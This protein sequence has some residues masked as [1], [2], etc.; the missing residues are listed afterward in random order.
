MWCVHQKSIKARDCRSYS[1]ANYKRDFGGETNIC[2]TCIESIN[3]VNKKTQKISNNFNVYDKPSADKENSTKASTLEMNSFD[4]QMNLNVSITCKCF[5]WNNHPWVQQFANKS[6]VE[7]IYIFTFLHF[8]CCCCARLL[9]ISILKTNKTIENSLNACD[10]VTFQEAKKKKDTECE[11]S[12]ERF[13]SSFV[14]ITNRNCLDCEFYA[15]SILR[16]HRLFLL[17]IRSRTQK[18]IE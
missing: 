18:Q 14:F 4:E 16:N 15:T 3:I 1:P 2:G 17:W 6:T 9:I 5:K 13:M 7:V 11:F 10:C 12:R 8:F